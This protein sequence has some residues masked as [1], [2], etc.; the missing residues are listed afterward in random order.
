MRTSATLAAAALAALTAAAPV[1]AQEQEL[2]R[3]LVSVLLS[4]YGGEG[5]PRILVGQLPDGFPREGV[6]EGARVVGSVVHSPKRSM[7]VLAV[8]TSQSEA[9]AAIERA[10]MATGR[11]ER[12]RGQGQRGFVSG[13]VAATPP[14]C[15]PDGATVWMSCTRGQDGTSYVRINYTGDGM[16]MC[17]AELRRAETVSMMSTDE[18]P[19]PA[20]YAPP[21]AKPGRTGFGGGLGLSEASTTLET[22]LSP[23]ELV[24]HY[25]PQVEQAGWT[26]LGPAAAA[27]PLAT[28]MF[29]ITDDK[30]RTWLGLLS[31]VAWPDTQKREMGFR[32]MDPA[33]ERF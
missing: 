17:A 28:R 30:G 13:G 24:A 12:H 29:R 2:P 33:A 19:I 22:S 10:L 6:P 7:V 23:A 4:D 9:M 26:P 5:E 18:G 32:A 15:G 31:A 27:G 1:T 3:E 16:S 21:G 20:L 25:G 8:R 11:W 14:L